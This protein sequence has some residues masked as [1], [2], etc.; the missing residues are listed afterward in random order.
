MSAHTDK[1]DTPAA[2]VKSLNDSPILETSSVGD[3][4]GLSSWDVSWNFPTQNIF[5]LFVKHL[6]KPTKNG[7]FIRVCVAGGAAG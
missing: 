6:F 5:M 4:L 2:D 7:R 1:Q 3:Y